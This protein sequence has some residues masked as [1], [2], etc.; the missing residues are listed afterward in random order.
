MIVITG[1]ETYQQRKK[2]S[3]EILGLH[4]KQGGRERERKKEE[5]VISVIY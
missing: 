5:I 2:F 3:K 4:K 1:E